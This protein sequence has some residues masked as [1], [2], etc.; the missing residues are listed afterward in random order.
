[1]TRRLSTLLIAVGVP[2][3]GLER[4]GGAQ[5]AGQSAASSATVGQ[6]R[7]P[8]RPTSRWR[9]LRPPASPA[10][11][12]TSR[13]RSRASRAS[14]TSS[15]R[16]SR[17]PSRRAARRR[18]RST[19][20]ARGQFTAANTTILGVSVDSTWSNKAFR[21]QLGVSFPILSDWKKD[22][23]RQYGLLNETNGTARRATFVV[24]KQGIVQKVDVGS[25]A[26]DPSASSACARSCTRAARSRWHS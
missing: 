20:R 23:S 5:P 4:A 3:G 11:S 9:G 19:R 13:S 26:L 22:A 7:R 15:S 24:D 6:G 16:S 2:R 10:S 12:R 14:R 18:C 8:A 21:E 25:D 17:P 1:M